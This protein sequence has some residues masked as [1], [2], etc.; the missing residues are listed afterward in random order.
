MSRQY[1][2]DDIAKYKA[3]SAMSGSGE[4]DSDKLYLTP[5]IPDDIPLPLEI[6]EYFTYMRPYFHY[7][8]INLRVTKFIINDYT[9]NDERPIQVTIVGF[10]VA[11][12]NGQRP[13][14]I[15]ILYKDEGDLQFHSPP[16]IRVDF[17]QVRPIHQQMIDFETF[18]TRNF[19]IGMW[20]SDTIDQDKQYVTNRLQEFGL[21]DAELQEFIGLSPNKFGILP[22]GATSFSRGN[23]YEGSG[24]GDW[25]ANLNA[26]QSGN[27]F[28][29]GV[30]TPEYYI[31]DVSPQEGEGYY[32]WQSN[33]AKLS[34]GAYESVLADHGNEIIERLFLMKAHN[35]Y[36]M[37]IITNSNNIGLY[38]DDHPTLFA[39][40]RSVNNSNN[41]QNRIEIPLK[42]KPL[43]LRKFMTKHSKP[44]DRFR[45]SYEYMF[46]R[47]LSN[48][49]ISN[50]DI[51]DFLALPQPYYEGYDPNP[52]PSE[53][54]RPD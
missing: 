48:D 18:I 43:T 47:L 4:K 30:P 7:I 31:G 26:L 23:G 35:L 10:E 19:P 28:V 1:S 45:N 27:G 14:R 22:P 15:K 5:V 34:G 24:Y 20:T 44:D 51:S 21:L 52:E 41:S 12:F 37:T 2:V 36:L 42:S 6:D 16:I 49:L 39:E 17:K 40:A 13:S 50:S 32:E 46:D 11:L 25:I 54:L 8:V 33:L 53:L 3:G 38:F 9:L 29:S